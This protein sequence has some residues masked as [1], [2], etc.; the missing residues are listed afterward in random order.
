MHCTLLLLLAAPGDLP[1]QADPKGNPAAVQPR[2]ER[3]W[4]QRGEWPLMGAVAALVATQFVVAGV[5]WYNA[6]ATLRREV[7]L[8]RIAAYS[9]RL[10]GFYNPVYAM[11]VA[12][13]RMFDGFGP[14][15]Y[16]DDPALA[17]V[18]VK[19]W[20]QVRATIILPNNEAMLAILR[21]KS[22]L[23]SEADDLSNY[24]G[25]L[26]HLM[27]YRLFVESATEKYR[28]YPFPKDVVGHIEGQIRRIKGELDKA[29]M[30]T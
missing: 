21:D 16:P 26:V 9:E 30:S 29:K 4:Y 20:H 24:S 7:N 23:I 12:N 14:P 11:C 28:N 22:H 15:A 6:R 2:D 17:D 19:L 27:A 3:E 25:L 8:R 18:A 13:G 1:P 5:A 10:S